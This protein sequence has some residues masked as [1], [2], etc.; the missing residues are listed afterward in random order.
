M[1]IKERNYYYICG[2]SNWFGYLLFASGKLSETCLLCESEQR[3]KKKRERERIIWQATSAYQIIVLVIKGKSRH[4]ADFFHELISEL[5]MFIFHFSAPRA[6]SAHFCRINHFQVDQ[7]RG[8][9]R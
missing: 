8:T 7:I 9:F 5:Y 2:A 6:S 1:C 4:R 3:R